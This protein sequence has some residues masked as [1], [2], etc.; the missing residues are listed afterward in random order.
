[1]VKSVESLSLISF[2]SWLRIV[3]L[4]KILGIWGKPQ[5][6]PGFHSLGTWTHL[7]SVFAFY[8]FIF[9]LCF[10]PY[11]V[12]FFLLYMSA[13][14]QISLPHL[15]T[16]QKRVRA[17]C[18]SQ[19]WIPMLTNKFHSIYKAISKADRFRTIWPRLATCS[20]CIP[21]ATVVS[22][23]KHE[24]WGSFHYPLAALQILVTSERS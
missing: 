15:D 6:A 14:S 22:N 1:M 3:K 7:S 16:C 12:T 19:K 21:K 5:K 2:K 4:L 24:R 11:D 18:Y 20:H 23:R 9:I 17:D 8:V 13:A 10:E